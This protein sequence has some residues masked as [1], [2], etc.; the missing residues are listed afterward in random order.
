MGPARADIPYKYTV[1]HLVPM[2]LSQKIL[3][4][5]FHFRS[6]FV[7]VPIENMRHEPIPSTSLKHRPVSALEVPRRMGR[8]PSA[9]RRVFSAKNLIPRG[10]LCARYK[11]SDRSLARVPTPAICATFAIHPLRRHYARSSRDPPPVPPACIAKFPPAAHLVPLT[12]GLEP[13]SPRTLVPTHFAPPAAPLYAPIRSFLHGSSLIPS[14]LPS[15]GA[16]PPP[17]PSMSTKNR[18][19]QRILRGRHTV[20]ELPPPSSL[21][22][23]PPRSSLFHRARTAIHDAPC[24]PAAQDIPPRSRV[25]GSPSSRDALDRLQAPFPV[26]TGPS[27]S[28]VGTPRRA[29][30]PRE[31]EST[32]AFPRAGISR[33]YIRRYGKPRSDAALSALPRPVGHP[34]PLIYPRSVYR[35]PRPPA[36][37]HAASRQ[38]AARLESPFVK[39]RSCLSADVDPQQPSPRGRPAWMQCILYV[40]GCVDLSARAAPCPRRAS[41][42]RLRLSFT[43]R[44]AFFT[45]TTPCPC[46]P[47]PAPEPC[48]ARLSLV[49]RRRYS[50]LPSHADADYSALVLAAGTHSRLRRHPPSSSMPTPW[51]PPTLRPRHPRAGAARRTMLLVAGSAWCEGVDS[52]TVVSLG[53][54][55]FAE[56]QWR[57]L[58]LGRR[59]YR[60]AGARGNALGARHAPCPALTAALPSASTRA[61]P[62][63]GAPHYVFLPG[64]VS[65]PIPVRSETSRGSGGGARVH[66]HHRLSLQPN[67]TPTHKTYQP[68]RTCMRPHPS[69]SV[70][71]RG[72]R[73]ALQEAHHDERA[74]LPP[75]AVGDGEHEREPQDEND[76]GYGYVRLS[77]PFPFSH[78]LAPSSR[79]SYG[80]G[81][82]FMSSRKFDIPAPNLEI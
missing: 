20:Y 5:R 72:A 70:P 47:A 73:R 57:A 56:P 58:E 44:A 9:L 15:L 71:V 68:Y 61:A 27:R 21:S 60:G 45:P 50:A 49:L 28:P 10:I 80:G 29:D 13:R 43:A 11:H 16:Q 24:P 4:A 38:P 37:L 77:L 75:H 40:S 19:S 55:C 22:P 53:A 76:D 79:T 54:E 36:N 48:I 26:R 65:P 64:A 62:R 78:Y 41:F 12:D 1:L 74:S 3:P 46:Y 67:S 14:S 32:P 66:A 7:F 25:R 35:P 52:N 17:P 59:R 63:K 18:I 23:S 2:L 6:W 30:A 82:N 33:C 31:A 8:L 42:A 81:Q 34:P 39:R 51:K 69:A